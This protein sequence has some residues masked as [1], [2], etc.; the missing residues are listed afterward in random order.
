MYWR[1]TL[2]SHAWRICV[3]HLPLPQDQCLCPRRQ[4]LKPHQYKSDRDS[5]PHSLKFFSM[6]SPTSH[7]FQVPCRYWFFSPRPSS[8]HRIII[9]PCRVPPRPLNT[10]DGRS[11]AA[12]AWERIANY[13]DFKRDGNDGSGPNYVIFASL[14]SSSAKK[15]SWR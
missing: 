15:W 7:S 13:A 9:R 1:H 5:L 12:A 10:K 3:S 11:C 14:V 8:K 4:R 2:L 6:Q